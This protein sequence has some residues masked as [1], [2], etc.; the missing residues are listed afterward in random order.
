MFTLHTI[1]IKIKINITDIRSENLYLLK[2]KKY[3][4][5]KKFFNVS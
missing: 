2:Q 5:R 1:D 4:N 3:Q